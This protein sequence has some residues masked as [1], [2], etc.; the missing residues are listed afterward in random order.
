MAETLVSTLPDSPTVLEAEPP[1]VV[2]TTQA[3]T[4]SY[5]YITTAKPR[6]KSST[7]MYEADRPWGTRPILKGNFS[8]SRSR[9]RLK[10]RSCSQIRMNNAGGVRHSESR[11]KPIGK[12]A[13]GG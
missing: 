7:A 13:E 8:R 12:I 10:D 2:E 9:G 11:A 4:D 1:L 6:G 3:V 5:A